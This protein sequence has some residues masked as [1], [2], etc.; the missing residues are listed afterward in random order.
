MV[1]HL[2]RATAPITIQIQVAKDLA[3]GDDLWIILIDRPSA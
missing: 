1:A 2:S 3:F